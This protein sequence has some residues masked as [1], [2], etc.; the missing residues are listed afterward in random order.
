MNE[1]KILQNEEICTTNDIA[2]KMH[3]YYQTLKHG[4]E[5][6]DN[7][8][9]INDIESNLGEI[10]EF[11]NNSYLYKTSLFLSSINENNII[12]QKKTIQRTWNRS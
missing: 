7:F 2:K 8:M 9:S 12:D 3:E 1:K 6:V 11:S 4:T 10:I 5:D